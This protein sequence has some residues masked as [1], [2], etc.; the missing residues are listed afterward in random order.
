[1]SKPAAIISD[2]VASQMA[3]LALRT[4]RPLIIADADEVLFQFMAKFLEFL[5]ANNY[6]FDWSSFALTG[7]IRD[8]DTDEVIEGRVIGKLMPRFF[9]EHAAS[10]E[11]VADAAQVLQRLSERAEIIVLSNVPLDARED[12]LS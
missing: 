6:R 4:D 7:N 2:A 12:R 9:S 8:A 3:E 5:E 10:M 11:P 1:M